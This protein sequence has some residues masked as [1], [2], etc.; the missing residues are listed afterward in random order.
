MLEFP[1]IARRRLS[2]TQQ[3]G[4][5]PDPG[6]LAA[7]VEGTIT[8]THRREV[9]DHLV[10]C[11][12]CNRVVALVVPEQALA[13]ISR[14]VP[15]SRRWFAWEPLRWAAASVA[16]AVV[17][18]VLWI[19]PTSHQPP[20]ATSASLKPSPS[21]TMA[22]PPASAVAQSSQAAR[23]P[24]RSPAPKPRELAKVPAS[25]SVTE[26][27]PAVAAESRPAVPGK[28]RGETAFQTSIISSAAPPLP[29]PAPA[30][31]PETSPALQPAAP[32]APAYIGPMMSVGENGELQRSVDGGRAWTAIAVPHRAPLRAL[33]IQNQDIWVGGDSGGL[34]HSTDGGQTWAAVAPFSNG[35]TLTDDITRIAFM[36]ERHGWLITKNGDNWVTVDGGA[37]WALRSARK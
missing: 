6:M 36:D 2:C 18:S 15:A 8:P 4:E 32:S 29:A 37:T 1:E 11:S 22:S 21:A 35:Q 5:H 14:P 26:F 24:L 10:G 23:E 9:L 20:A 13:P 34:F 28:I 3:P 17:V 30:V 19:G 7:F 25:G 12:E 16:A 27:N 33:S 31:T